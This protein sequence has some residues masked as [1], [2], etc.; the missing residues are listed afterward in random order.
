MGELTRVASSMFVAVFESLFHVRLEG[1][2]RNPQNKDEYAHNAQRVIDSLSERIQMDLQHITGDLIVRGDRNALSNL[3][4]I[5]VRIVS[6]TSRES[7]EF[8]GMD[9]HL[10][11]DHIRPRHGSDLGDSLST[12]ESTFQNSF[13]NGPPKPGNHVP[14]G[15]VLDE[16]P[17]D[18]ENSMRDIREV[19]MSMSDQLLKVNNRDAR[20]LFKSSQNG[21]EQEERMEAARRRRATMQKIREN[22]SV[23][24]NKRRAEISNKALQRRWVEDTKRGNDAF[25]MRKENEEAVMLRKMYRGLLSKMHE[26]GSEEQNELRQK[27]TEMKNEASWHIKSLQALFEDRVTLLREQAAGKDDKVLSEQRHMGME[28]K[29]SLNEQRDVALNDQKSVIMQ[30]RQYQMMRR[31]EGQKTLLSFIAVEK[32]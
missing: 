22:S 18:N 13:L 8:S 4:H 23:T 26:W 15:G 9:I 16:L 10:K 3:V 30:K 12:H 2:I 32:W 19:S 6:M 20:R 24:A 31:R 7:L 25:H 27:V 1:I 29:K 14:M 5:F 11:G 28:L 17:S 21:F